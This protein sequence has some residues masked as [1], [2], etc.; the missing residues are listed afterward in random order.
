MTDNFDSEAETAKVNGSVSTPHAPSAAA[1]ND[2]QAQTR[3]ERSKK[4]EAF[5]LSFASRAHQAVTTSASS[6]SEGKTPLRIIVTGGL[7]TR[8]GMA[9]CVSSGG[10][11][12][13]GLGR[14]SVVDP[15]LAK[16]VL[17]SEKEEVG[18]KKYII[19]AS[20]LLAHIPIQ[21]VGAGWATLWH[22]VMLHWLAYASDE[23][24]ERP[25]TRT[26]PLNAGPLRAGLIVALGS[27]V[28]PKEEGR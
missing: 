16:R 3:T 6:S 8:A 23:S 24:G 2:A 5:F 26:Q 10:A 21:V 12:G 14:A 25:A 17:S 1:A 19:P 11:D 22:T 18:V 20:G 15:H 13:V 9:E 27:W 28:V 4:R 7:K